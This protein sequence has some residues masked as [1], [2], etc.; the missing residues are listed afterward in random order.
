MIWQEQKLRDAV[1]RGDRIATADA[2]VLFYEIDRLRG[3]LEKVKD[4]AMGNH[5][6]RK[7]AEEALR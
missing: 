3:A 5:L 7:I 1:R 2:E 4:K 6:V